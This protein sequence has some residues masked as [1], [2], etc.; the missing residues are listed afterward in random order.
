[1]YVERDTTSWQDLKDWARQAGESVCYGDV[2][3]DCGR[4][5]GIVE[6]TTKDDYIYAIKHL[7]N[8]KLQKTRF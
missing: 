8:D 6:Y 3:V 7:N 5:M 2:F 1:M 4:R